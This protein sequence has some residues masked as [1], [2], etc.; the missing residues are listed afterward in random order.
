MNPRVSI[1]L[2]ES[3]ARF[4]AGPEQTVLEAALQA[5][6]SLPHSCTLGGCGSCRV[7]IQSGQVRYEEWPF[8]LSEEEAAQGQ[9]LACQAPH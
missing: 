1:Q 9:A 4:S 5:G 8:G 2:L 7:Q 6:L 3:G